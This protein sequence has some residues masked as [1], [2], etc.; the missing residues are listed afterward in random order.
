M[1]Y[2][3]FDKNLVE[4]YKQVLYREMYG[5]IPPAPEK[6]LFNIRRQYLDFAGKVRVVEFFVRANMANGETAI[7]PINAYFPVNAKK[8]KTIVYVSREQAVPHNEC[9]L[10][11]IIDRGYNLIHYRYDFFVNHSGRLDYENNKILLKLCPN[12]GKM[13]FWIWGLSRTYEFLSMLDEVDSKNIGIVGND[14]AGRIVMA[15]AAFEDRFAFAHSNCSGTLG[16]SLFTSMDENSQPI[17]DAML[18]YEWALNERFHA[19]TDEHIVGGYHKV[20]FDVELPLS[21]LGEDFDQH[22]HGYLIAPRP[23]SVGCA[24]EDLLSSPNGTFDFCKAISNAYESYG[25]KGLVAPE[26]FAVGERYYDGNVGFYC[27]K[28]ARFFGREDWNNLMDFFDSN[29]NK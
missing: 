16:A 13:A 1:V 9:P 18:W 4:K 12:S 17:N 29:L 27:R 26:K 7:F 8:N 19:T 10:E 3:K 15:A 5:E 24:S 2:S 25:V 20:D 22:L 23:F 14:I 11:E 28:G 6:V 21:K